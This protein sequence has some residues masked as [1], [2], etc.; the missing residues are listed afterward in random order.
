LGA[1]NSIGKVTVAYHFTMHEALS[2]IENSGDSNLREIFENL[3]S[4]SSR[5]STDLL[6]E[7]IVFENFWL[8]VFDCPRDFASDVVGKGNRR[9]FDD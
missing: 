8:K 2:F 3:I 1:G 5:F 4:R 6:V 9:H 7:S